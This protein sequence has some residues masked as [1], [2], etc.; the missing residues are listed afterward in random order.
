MSTDDAVTQRPLKVADLER[1]TVVPGL[2][3]CVVE[4]ETQSYQYTWLTHSE[5]IHIVLMHKLVYKF[6]H[7][8]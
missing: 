1:S 5:Q 7:L 8:Q 6:I 4:P 3:L 2:G